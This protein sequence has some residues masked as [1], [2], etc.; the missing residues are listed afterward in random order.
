MGIWG[1]RVLILAE[2]ERPVRAMIDEIGSRGAEVITVAGVGWALAAL[3]GIVPDVL[4]VD[5]DIPRV[6]G[7]GLVRTVRSLSPEKGGRVPA[8]SVS[9][10]PLR[11]ARLQEWRVGLF[12]AHFPP[13][14]PRLVAGAVAR[15]AGGAVERRRRD[16]DR[17]YW[18]AGLRHDRR[19]EVRADRPLPPLAVDG[20]LRASAEL[21]LHRG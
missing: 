11:S 1:A 3:V 9:A 8:V 10:T 13:T 19:A 12:Q 17:R 18:P 14:R 21:A 7:L 4:V 16:L 20:L 2:D 6:D 5:L 15:L